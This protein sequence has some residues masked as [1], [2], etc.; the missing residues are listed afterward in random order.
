MLAKGF[1]LWC[2][3]RRLFCLCLIIIVSIVRTSPTCAIDNWSSVRAYM[4]RQAETPPVIDG[5]LDDSC[6]AAAETATGFVPRRAERTELATPQ[7]RVWLCYDKSALYVA[8]E[9]EEPELGNLVTEKRRRDTDVYNDDMV[10]LLLDV[11][12]HRGNH[13]DIE[14]A[15]DAAGTQYDFAWGFEEAWDGE[16]ICATSRDM[17]RG[18]WWAEIRIP[19]SDT[20]QPPVRGDIWGLQAMR[21]RYAGG[22][23]EISIWSAVPGSWHTKMWESSAFGHLLFETGADV[24]SAYVD[25]LTKRL[26]SERYEAVKLVATSADP[27]SARA[28]LDS[29]YGRLLA[30]QDK[31]ALGISLS[32]D[33]WADAFVESDSILETYEDLIWPI[34]M[35]AL[36][37]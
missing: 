30:L 25:K 37:R 27:D 4:C 34:K 26:R 20:R 5:V 31:V 32:G 18:I 19:A 7:T 2:A 13:Y 29:I 16:W 35:E 9:C 11:G 24:L 12:H 10:G 36:F 17:G 23:E 33:E 21:W 6:W 22:K 3:S 28:M 1:S 8:Y 14:I 15:L